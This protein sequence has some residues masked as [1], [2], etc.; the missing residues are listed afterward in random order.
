MGMLVT[1]QIHH[2]GPGVSTR[3]IEGPGSVCASALDFFFLG[4]VSPTKLIMVGTLGGD[5]NVRITSGQ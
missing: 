5:A 4:A 2:D 1:H 3:G